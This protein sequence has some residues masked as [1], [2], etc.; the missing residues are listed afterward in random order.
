MTA[1]AP[2]TTKKRVRNSGD[3]EKPSPRPAAVGQPTKS[4]RRVWMIALGITVV[5]IGA[6]AT[7]YVT[8]TTSQT[9]SVLTIRADV[10]SEEHTSELQSREN[11]VCRL[12]LE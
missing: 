8:T 10:R 11:L 2:E 6:L 7:W 4:R 9:T 1:T 12:L 3:S 5:L